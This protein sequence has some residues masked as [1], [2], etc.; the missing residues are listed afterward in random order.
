MKRLGV[1]VQ[2][3]RG[4]RAKQRDGGMILG[5]P[6][7][8]LANLPREGVSVDLDR[9]IIDQWPGLDMGERARART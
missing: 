9:T 8:S 5:N 1:S 6:R 7:S 3:Y 2:D 4:L